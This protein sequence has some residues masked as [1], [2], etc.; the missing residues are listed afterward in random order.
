MTEE[1]GLW[2]HRLKQSHHGFHEELNLFS[3]HFNISSLMLLSYDETTIGKA[4]E[5]GSFFP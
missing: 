3:K 2:M 5:M 1:Q 4:S